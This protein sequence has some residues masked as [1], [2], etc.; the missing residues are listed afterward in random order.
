MSKRWRTPLLL[1]TLFAALGVMTRELPECLSL[2]DDVSNDGDV[3]VLCQKELLERVLAFETRA[4]VFPACLATIFGQEPCNSATATRGAP[5]LKSA[6]SLL[7]LLH[8]QR[9]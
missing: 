2:T 9:K 6:R 7:L 8:V 4:S 3:P 1:L 5:S